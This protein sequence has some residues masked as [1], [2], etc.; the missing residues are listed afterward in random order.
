MYR[1]ALHGLGAAGLIPAGLGLPRGKGFSVVTR[2]F[3]GK[4]QTNIFQIPDFDNSDWDHDAASQSSGTC[5]HNQGLGGGGAPTKHCCLHCVHA[6][7]IYSN[8]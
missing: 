7:K 4:Y 1:I 6:R 3:R 5:P 2:N 8:T